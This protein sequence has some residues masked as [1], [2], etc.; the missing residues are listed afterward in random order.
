MK[1]IFIIA[2]ATSLFACKKEALIDYAIISGSVLNTVGSESLSINAMDRSFTKTLKVAEDGSFTDTLKTKLNDYVLYDGQ[3]PVFLYLNAGD[4]IVINYDVKDFSNTLKI[5][6]DG[7]RISNYLIAKRAIE[8]DKLGGNRDF[9]TLDEAAY[10]ELFDQ[11]ANSQIE[12]L[13][14]TAGLPQ[15]YVEKERRNINYFYLNMLSDYES[16]HKY[17][18]RKQTFKVSEGFLTELESLDYDNG[19]DYE[20]SQYYKKIVN[21][22][23]NRKAGEIARDQQLSSGGLA[24]IEALSTSNQKIKNGILFNYANANLVRERDPKTFYDAYMVN[25]NNEEHKAKITEILK[26]LTATNVGAASPKFI[27]YEN[28]A[29]GTTSLDDLKGKYVYIDVWATWCGPCIREIPAL[30]KIEKQFHGKN[31]EFVSISIDKKKDYDKWKKMIV[32]KDLGGIQLLADND[33]KS[34]F[35][36]DYGIEGI[37]RFILIDPNGN[38]VSA[39]APRPSNP[40]LISM[41]ENLE[42]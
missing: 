29:G 24:L 42:I 10:K 32:D 33:W 22:Y 6:G 35:V 23:Y 20:A 19:D 16:A 28:N 13:E 7:S 30:K 26:K 27:N 15:D 14:K 40:S 5:T 17:Y 8:T 21:S 37:P 2:L 34:S 18:T 39:N 4:N 11:I 36:Q 9:F 41:I 3:N 38:I 1:K 12:T 25:S 31:I